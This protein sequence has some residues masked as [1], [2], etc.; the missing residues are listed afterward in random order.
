MM[1]YPAFAGGLLAMALLAMAAEP[2]TWELNDGHVW[3]QVGLPTTT[4]TTRPTTAP[5]AED[6]QTIDS[7]E[8]LIENKQ[9]GAADKLDVYWLLNHKV[10]PLRE[11]ALYLLGQ[12]NMRGGNRMEAFYNFDEL[13]DKFPESKYFYPAL[14]RQYEIADDYLH[15]YK[16]YFLGLPL[17]DASD[18]AVEMLFRIQQ[19]SPGSALAEKA[20]LR[21]GDYYYEDSQFDLAGDVYGVYIKSYPRSPHVP[22]VRL[23]QAF[24]NYAQFRGTKFDASPIIDARKQLEMIIID[25]PELA[26]AENLAP[27]IAR[28]DV[29]FA[30]KL[31]VTAEFYRR[32]HEPQAAVYYYR[33][34]IKTFPDA[35]QAQEARE[36]LKDM[37][38]SALKI[39]EP[40]AALGYAPT[41]QSATR[42]ATIPSRPEVH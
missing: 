41:T 42:P 2:R 29:T 14:Q 33:F 4:P 8:Q 11:R 38:A 5:T 36:T 10:S 40:P 12:A 24:A 1:H 15:G 26:K 34:L 35:P 31:L 18:E 37:P 27:V 13:L 32:T 22:R 16:R 7:V 21:T 25:Y 19:R 3:E 23:R 9:Y 17:L 28:I 20:L 30:Q 6:Y 39:P